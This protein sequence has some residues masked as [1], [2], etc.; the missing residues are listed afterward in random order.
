MELRIIGCT[1]SMSGP[2]SA[3]SCY[4]V[5]AQALDPQ[6]GEQRWW[7]IVLDLGPGSFGQLWKHID[8]IDVDA[9]IFSHCHADHMGDIISM[10]VYRR[11][12]PGRG[13]APL[14]VYGPEG[15]MDRV[16]QID[17]VGEEELYATEFDF[18]TLISGR[19]FRV[20]PLTVTPHAG[21]HSVPSFGIRIEGPTESGEARSFFYTGDTDECDSIVRGADRAHLLLTEAGFT[22]ADEVRG[23]HLDGERAGR[24]ATRAEVES[25]VLTHI[26]PWVNADEVREAARQTWGGPLDIAYADAVFEV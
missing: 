3:A 8:P 14:P 16:R 12:G 26:Q 11:W 4:L 23:I 6:T 24:V 22:G 9:L 25:V 15:V 10:H 7:N 21:W 2:A 5:R 17:G 20:G 13:N 1:G 18:N 19:A